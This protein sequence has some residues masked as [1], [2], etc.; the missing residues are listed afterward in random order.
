MLQARADYAPNPEAAAIASSPDSLLDDALGGLPPHDEATLRAYALGERPYG[1]APA[2]FRKRVERGRVVHGLRTGAAVVPM[3]ALSWIACD[4][5]AATVLGGIALLA[6]VTA[7]VWCGQEPGRATRLGLMAGT[8]CLLVPV[9]VRAT[10]H[11]CGA[12]VCLFYPAA[13]L[14]GGVLGGL[15]L[16]LLARRAGLGP[17]GLTIAGTVAWLVGSLGCIMAGVTGIAVLVV[18]LAFGLA[19]TLTLRRA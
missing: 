8:P 9:L 3:A 6:L 18:G 14:G 5:P 13:C 10:G 4:N 1:V 7:A 16:G 19:P 17:L 12:S 11:L 15:A 2:T